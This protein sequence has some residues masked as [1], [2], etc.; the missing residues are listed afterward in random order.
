MIIE[1]VKKIM[2]V[3][4]TPPE[5]HT[6]PHCGAGLTRLVLVSGGIIRLGKV[7]KVKAIIGC[8]DCHRTHSFKGSGV[9]AHWL[10]LQLENQSKGRKG[11]R[12]EVLP[13]PASPKKET[14][15]HELTIHERGQTQRWRH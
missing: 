13:W 2:G 5:M 9:K 10:I 12:G 4:A 7:S 11:L 6:C 14:L 3:H 8:R 15:S 1:A